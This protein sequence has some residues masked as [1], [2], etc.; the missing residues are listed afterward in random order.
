MIDRR[1]FIRAGA[2][3]IG[4]MTIAAVLLVP[5]KVYANPKGAARCEALRLVDFSL[6]P[7]ATTRITAVGVT[8]PNQAGCAFHPIGGMGSSSSS[9]VAGLVERWLA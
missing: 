1:K 5:G 7:D 2:T 3:F 9:A 4:V 6:I 8:K